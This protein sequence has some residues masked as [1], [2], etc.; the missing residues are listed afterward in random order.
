MCYAAQLW[1]LV[2]L[3]GLPPWA[4]SGLWHQ[5]TMSPTLCHA[6][7]ASWFTGEEIRLGHY[8][9]PAQSLPLSS[10]GTLIMKEALALLL[11]NYAVH[12]PSLNIALSELLLVFSCS[13][14]RDS[15]LDQATEQ[16]PS[17]KICIEHRV[18]TVPGVAAQELLQEVSVLA[19]LLPLVSELG[20]AS[21]EN[22]FFSH[23]RQKVLFAEE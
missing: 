13:L 2:T 10:S 3:Q 11:Y 9:I 1:G 5:V 21:S 12:G 23:G 16:P 22:Y 7:S 14:K 6:S 17:N 15:N 18:D 4:G 8:H 20:L 19:R